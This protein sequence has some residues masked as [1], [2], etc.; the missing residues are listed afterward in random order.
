MKR[1]LR[2]RWNLRIN[3]FKRTLFIAYSKRQTLEGVTSRV[4]TEP[5]EK[6][7]HYIF[8]DLENCTLEQVKQKLKEIQFEFKLGDIFIFSDRES[9]YRA[10][11]FSKRP[12]LTFLHILIHSFPFLDYGFW[13]WTVRRGAA[14]LRTSQK[15]DRPNQDLVAVLKG[16]EETMIPDKLRYVRY[17]TG[18][19]KKGRLIELG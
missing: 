16:Y 11:C 5:E 15:V 9:S 2:M 6:H 8:F 14:T 4:I 18:V 17:D 13:V 1:G 3:L 19:E 7:L 12:W 10:W